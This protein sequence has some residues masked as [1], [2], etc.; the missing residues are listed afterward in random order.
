VGE[1]AFDDLLQGQMVLVF[2]G[3]IVELFTERHGSIARIHVRQLHHGAT[4][5]GRKGQYEYTCSPR[6][7]WP[8]GGFNVTVD[9]ETWRSLQ[10]LIAEI[11]AA[12]RQ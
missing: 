8:G 11:D 10:Q 12:A 2:D 5:P 3:R 9:G 7:T 1:L 4:G 6:S